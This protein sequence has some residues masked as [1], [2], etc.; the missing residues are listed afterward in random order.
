MAQNPI[1][2]PFDQSGGALIA[3]C[4]FLI[5]KSVGL[6]KIDK[7]MENSYGRLWPNR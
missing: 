1:K 4:S 5:G 6:I 2:M 3:E 7:E